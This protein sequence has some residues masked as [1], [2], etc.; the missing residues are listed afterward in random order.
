MTRTVTNH[1]IIRLNAQ[2]VAALFPEGSEARVDLTDKVIAAAVE[3]VR[4]GA[5]SG[6]LDAKIKEH[7]GAVDDIVA[8]HL[9]TWFKPQGSGWSKRIELDPTY[10]QK[11][12]QGL[13]EQMNKRTQELLTEG[14]NDQ[15]LEDRVKFAIEEQVDVAVRKWIARYVTENM[16]EQIEQRVK[17]KVIEAFK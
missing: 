15:T 6:T 1:P 2:A 9:E 16:K 14:L 8:K 7:L 17:E 11:L 12:E 4:K 13:Q 5:I 10:S 3:K